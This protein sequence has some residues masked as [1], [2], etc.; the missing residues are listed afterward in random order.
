MSDQLPEQPERQSNNELLTNTTLSK[1][2]GGRK[3]LDP[4]LLKQNQKAGAKR[5]MQ[6]KRVWQANTSDEMMDKSDRLMKLLRI[7]RKDELLEWLIAKGELYFARIGKK[8][9]LRNARKGTE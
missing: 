6:G 9:K 2:R 1:N 4:E 3:R 7:R 5:R 8:S